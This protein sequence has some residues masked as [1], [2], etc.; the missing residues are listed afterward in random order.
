[1]LNTTS[2]TKAVII[3]VAK[4]MRQAQKTDSVAHVRNRKGDA[5]LAIR[6]RV[7]DGKVLF[8]VLDKAGRNIAGILTLA[9]V[10]L[11]K[12]SF[13]PNSLASI[14]V[15]RVAFPYNLTGAVR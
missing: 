8:Q 10:R 1:M 3:K 13:I 11:V 6:K 4:A 12:G 2:F 9:A 14:L 15:D 5:F 7:V